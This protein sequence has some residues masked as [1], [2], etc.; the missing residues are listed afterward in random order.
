MGTNTLTDRANGQTI[1][2]V[3]FNDIHSAMNGDFVGRNSSG[4]ATSLQNLGTN[5]IPWGSAYINSLIL[6]GSAVD[7]SLLTAPKNRIVSGKVR[8][9]SNQPQFLL[10][11]GAAASF[12]LE[13][14]TTNLVLDIDG[15]ASTVSTDI[16]K[17]SLTVGPST[18]HT[19]LVDDT[20]AADQESTKTWGEYGAEKETITVDTMGAEFQ[21]FIGQ[22]QIVQ[23]AGTATEYA[24]VYV[25]SATELTNAYRGFFTNSSSVPVNRVGF[26]NNDTITVLS[27]GWV[28]MENDSATVDVSY[29][30]PIR[31]FTAPSSPAAGDYWYDLAN[32]TWKRYDGASFQIINRI[33]IGVVGIDSSNCVCARSFDTFA[34]Y[35][36]TNNIEVEIQTTEIVQ[37]KN[38]NSKINVY[39]NEFEYG[40]N[41]ESWN[42]TTDLASSADMYNA[43]EQASTT[44]YL[45]LS[46]AG[47]TIISDISPHFRPDLKGWYHPHNTWRLAGKAHN[48]GSSDITLVIDSLPY[49]QNKLSSTSANTSVSATIPADNTIPQISEGTEIL[50]LDFLPKQG[51][52][53]LFCD[54]SG[55]VEEQTN[56]VNSLTCAL[57]RDTESDA[58]AAQLIATLGDSS[59]NL[60]EFSIKNKEIIPKGHG[61]ITIS[62][63][64]G[65]NASN[66]IYINSMSSNTLGGTFETVLSITERTEV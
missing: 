35:E 16:V 31:S 23:I 51:A 61:V 38:Q 6:D 5:A 21:N 58:F 27:T 48:D 44:Y 1:L 56:G 7:T 52:R 11:N 55:M 34:K 20:D 43:T 25:K 45:Y 18:T 63:R 60:G 62:V 10:P 15:V 59:L 36:E 13:A 26:T 9:T 14:A 12:T 37:F 57:F 64:I 32:E 3:F 54:F 47:E 22:W 24:L 40:F 41:H 29:K 17:S 8:T 39:G 46:D 50:T 28:F 65:A 42:M 2:D 66:T 49:L 19:A 33:L 53:R 4:V 30:T